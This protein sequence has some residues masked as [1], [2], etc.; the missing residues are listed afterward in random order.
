M[1]TVFAN[2]LYRSTRAS[3]I[4]PS[5]VGS[6]IKQIV[7]H[8]R[9]HRIP[10]EGGIGILAGQWRPRLKGTISMGSSNGGIIADTTNYVKLFQSRN[11]DFEHYTVEHYVRYTEK[12]DDTVTDLGWWYQSWDS[13]KVVLDVLVLTPRSWSCVRAIETTVTRWSQPW[14]YTGGFHRWRTDET[15]GDRTLRYWR[16]RVLQEAW[17]RTEPDISARRSLS[18]ALFERRGNE[19]QEGDWFGLRFSVSLPVVSS[20]ASASCSS[21]A[22]TYS[23]D[24]DGVVV[25]E[26]TSPSTTSARR[27]GST[28]FSYPR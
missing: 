28:I 14:W 3:V 25:D 12:I 26:Y 2:P 22:A 4:V 18:G 16:F 23:A 13:T 11:K 27:R 21:S 10:Q 24:I 9:E 15:I 20:S 5:I 7:L 6:W 17:T 1:A 19:R 8:Q